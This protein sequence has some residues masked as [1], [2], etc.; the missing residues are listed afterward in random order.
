MATH[1][2]NKQHLREVILF[3]FVIKKS[4]AETHKILVEAYGDNAP[5]KATCKRWF[6]RFR[7]GEFMV[8]DKERPGQ[9]QVFEDQDLEALLTE[10]P[11]QTQTDLSKSLN[12]SQSSISRRLKAMGKIYKVGRWVPHDLKPKD[13]E[14]RKVTSEILL[15]RQKRK[16]FLYRII[17]GDEK[18]IY[19]ENPKRRKVICDPGQPVKATPKRNIHGKKVLLSIW[20]DQKGVI[21][22]ELLKQGETVT[23]DLYREQ[24]IRLSQALHEKRPEYEKRQH[25]VILLHDNARPHVTKRVQEMLQLLQWEVLPHAPYSPD[26]APSDYHL[27]RSMAHSLSKK[28]FQIFEDIEKWITDWTATKDAHFFYRGIHQ[29]PERWEK[30]IANDGNYFE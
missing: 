1:I 9:T 6:S 27:F 28:R 29:L 4:A 30:V 8:E 7:K 18:W 22:H 24:I 13:M 11:C 16:G 19:F 14:R 12:V 5:S 25:K 23:G 3:H 26:C 21:Y 2:P 17:T 15:A 20:W 10:D